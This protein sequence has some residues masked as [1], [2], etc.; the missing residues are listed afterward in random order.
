MSRRKRGPL[1]PGW[2]LARDEDGM[3]RYV[4]PTGVSYHF[5]AC[6]VCADLRPE[7]LPEVEAAAYMYAR[8]MKVARQACWEDYRAWRRREGR[9]YVRGYLSIW[10]E[11]YHHA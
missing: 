9:M 1:P 2:E 8:V 5:P 10:E 11:Y 4:G 3:W 6:F 7:G